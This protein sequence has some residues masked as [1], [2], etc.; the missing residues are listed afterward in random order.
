MSNKFF[1]KQVML[2]CNKKLYFLGKSINFTNVNECDIDKN[3]NGICQ[4]KKHLQM[5][6]ITKKTMRKFQNKGRS[7]YKNRLEYR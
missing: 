1:D 7:I 4:T 2:K 5:A 3:E 6:E